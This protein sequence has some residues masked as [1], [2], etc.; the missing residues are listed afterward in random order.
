M[1]NFRWRPL[2]IIALIFLAFGY[3]TTMAGDFIL[4]S[5]QIQAGGKIAMEQVFDS[6]GCT[7]KNISPELHWTGV[8]KGTKSLALTVYDPDAPTGSGWWHW[9]IFNIDPRTT[10]LPANTGDVNAHL[11]PAGSVQSR[12][13][14]GSVGYGGPCPP[15]GDKPHRYIFTLFALDV[16]RLDLDPN[17]SAAMVGFNLNQHAI[18]KA[19]ITALFGRKK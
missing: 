5:S 18:G 13:D 14:F 11:A 1:N 9:L 7:G 8:P 17:A 2:G 10:G 19:R 15:P 6:F 4:E 12:T 16:D 3:Q